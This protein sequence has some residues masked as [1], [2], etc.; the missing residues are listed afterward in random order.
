M[1]AGIVQVPGVINKLSP[2]PVTLFMS[3]HFEIRM[4]AFVA[5]I[6]CSFLKLADEE[7]VFKSIPWK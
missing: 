1:Y 6:L 7:E 3:R 2:N 4:L 5:G